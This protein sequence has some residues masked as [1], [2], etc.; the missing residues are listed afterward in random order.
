MLLGIFLFCKSSCR[1]SFIPMPFRKNSRSRKQ[2]GSTG[3]QIAGNRMDSTLEELAREA[4]VTREER[5]LHFKN[6]A[7]FRL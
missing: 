3:V 1:Y 4:M 7:V 2:L 5:E 6:R